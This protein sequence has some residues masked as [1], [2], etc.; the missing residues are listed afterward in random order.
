MDLLSRISFKSRLILLI[1]LIVLP[2]SALFVQ[3]LYVDLSKIET[4]EREIGGI[5]EIKDCSR[6][7][8]Y[9]QKHRGLMCIYLRGYEPESLKGRIRRIESE[10]DSLFLKLEFKHSSQG[11]R[12]RLLRLKKEFENLK[13]GKVSSPNLSFSSHTEIIEE[14]MEI[15]KE[16]GE[17]YRILSDPN[18]F[19]RTLADTALIEIPKL[20]E[21]IGRIRGLG[22]GILAKGK[23]T[24]K[25]REEIARLYGF[26]VGYS[27]V[28]S[29]T[30]KNVKFPEEIISFFRRANEEL[31]GVHSNR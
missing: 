22:G 29:W 21:V 19:V 17:E 23:G 15:S 16:E 2:L 7:I 5:A 8:Y 27:Q 31:K 4:I 14:I 1:S 10:I 20:A 9:L 6:L 25:G 30:T 26:L 24:K 18:L 11:I 12:R 3:T 28:V 13:L